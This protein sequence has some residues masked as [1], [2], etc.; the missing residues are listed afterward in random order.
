MDVPLVP[1]RLELRDGG[2]GG[3]DG[4][5]ARVGAVLARVVVLPVVV[6]VGMPL[7]WILVGDDDMPWPCEKGL[8]LSVALQRQRFFVATLFLLNRLHG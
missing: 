5:N 8:F 3:P 4:V 1:H 6:V 7:R 2:S